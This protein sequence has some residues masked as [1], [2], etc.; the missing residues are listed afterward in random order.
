MLRKQISEEVRKKILS[1]LK[2]K[3]SGGEK[4]VGKASPGGDN[5]V[6]KSK[7]KVRFSYSH[8]D[9]IWEGLNLDDPEQVLRDFRDGKI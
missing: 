5:A 4:N 3:K 2:K 6:D 8:P 9:G 7:P 1:E